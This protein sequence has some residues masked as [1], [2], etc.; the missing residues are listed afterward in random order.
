MNYSCGVE[1]IKI[2]DPNVTSELPHRYLLFFG[3]LWFMF[4]VI[5]SLTSVKTFNFVGLLWSVGTITYPFTYIFDDIFTEVYGYRVS[6]KVIWSGFFA[7]FVM[8]IV[9]Y[10]YSLIPSDPSFQNDA[11]FNFVF[12]ASKYRTFCSATQIFLIKF[13]LNQKKIFF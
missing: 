1:K 11:A 2:T 5:N 12:Q 6:R 3:I 8:S 13:F 4:W 7:F 10:L 9:G